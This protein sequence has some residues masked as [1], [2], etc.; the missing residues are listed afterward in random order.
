[1]DFNETDENMM[2]SICM[3]SAGSATFTESIKKLLDIFLL[4]VDLLSYQTEG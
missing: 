3:Y 4:V 1:M 2:I